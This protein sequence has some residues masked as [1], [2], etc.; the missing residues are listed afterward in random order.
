L[1]VLYSTCPLDAR[2]RYLQKRSVMRQRKIAEFVNSNE[3]VE[4][5][6]TRKFNKFYLLDPTGM[7]HRK[8][9]DY[10]KAVNVRRTFFYKE[11]GWFY[12]GL[13]VL[14]ILLGSFFLFFPWLIP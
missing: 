7:T 2:W 8:D 3:F 13:M 11:I 6:K 12:G 14:S 1:Y 5:F 4:A 9:D 10:R